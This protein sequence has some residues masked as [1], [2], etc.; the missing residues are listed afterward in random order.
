MYK[1][2][3]ALVTLAI[4]SNTNACEELPTKI[5]SDLV[6]AEV[7]SR[8]HMDLEFVV[9]N[10]EDRFNLKVIGGRNY[11][12]SNLPSCESSAVA[13]INWSNSRRIGTHWTSTQ[14]TYFSSAYRVCV[15]NARKEVI[16]EHSVC[17][18][19]TGD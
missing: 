16:E 12:E 11:N 18:W 9:V 1:L 3:L 8:S 4:F 13:P 6:Y 14:S 2:L 15:L 5:D 10:K 19:E 7:I 17:D